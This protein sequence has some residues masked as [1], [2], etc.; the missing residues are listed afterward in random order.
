M[1]SPTGMAARPITPAGYA[2]LERELQDLWHKERPK[3]VNEVSEAAAM[4]DRSENAEYTYGKKR[5]REIDRRMKFLTE[6]L[7]KLKVI[8]PAD[9]A[10]DR[11]D[12]GATVTIEDEEGRVRTYTIVGEDEVD[13]KNGRI[14]MRSPVGKALLKRKVGDDVLVQRPAG[15]IEM[16]LIELKYGD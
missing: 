10:S 13:A 11:V 14:S 4:G 7:K 15:E 8:D 6:L 2:R 16:T 5:L 3:I 9:N 1:P 12:F